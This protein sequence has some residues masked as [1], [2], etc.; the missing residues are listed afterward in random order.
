LLGEK[1]EEIFSDTAK[2]T[3]D[4]ESNEKE[5]PFHLEILTAGSWFLRL[6]CMGKSYFIYNKKL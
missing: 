5:V 2:H 3:T 6:G 4:E 1:E